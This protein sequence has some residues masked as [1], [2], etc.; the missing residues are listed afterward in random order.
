MENIQRSKKNKIM[1]DSTRDNSDVH[2]EGHS[3]DLF[4]FFLSNN[5]GVGN[6]MHPL[7]TLLLVPGK[8]ELR[9]HR[10]KMKWV[11]CEHFRVA[12]GEGWDGLG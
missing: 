3:S 5:V 2:V 9:K 7:F 6:A 10:D 12:Q 4:Y 1:H 8:G 11:E